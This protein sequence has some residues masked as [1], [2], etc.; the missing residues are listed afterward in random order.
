FFFGVPVLKFL[1]KLTY[2]E[3]VEASGS[4]IDEIVYPSS[5]S[6]ED[7][8]DEYGN[9]FSEE[10]KKRLK[11]Y[12]LATYYEMFGLA[13]YSAFQLDYE[14]DDL[15][16]RKSVKRLKLDSDSSVENLESRACHSSTSVSLGPSVSTLAGTSSCQDVV[17]VKQ[18]P[19]DQLVDIN[20][21]QNDCSNHVEVDEPEADS[22]GEKNE[23][24][25]KEEEPL[26]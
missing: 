2:S 21:C 18:E 20:E 23:E 11:A 25:Q 26:A 8:I 10:E 22:V 19:K 14:E 4:P 24:V 3:N 16:D 12:K 9:P 15:E 1:E 17:G 13:D 7:L 5:E 6:E